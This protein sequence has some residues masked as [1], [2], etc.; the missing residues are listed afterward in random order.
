FLALSGTADPIAPPDV[1][2]AALDRMA[3]PRGHVLLTGQ[4]H[5]LDPASAADIVTWALGFLAAWVDGDAA[6]KSKL[7]QVEHVDGGLDDHKV[8]YVDPTG[9][10]VPGQ[11]VDTIEYYNAS[12]DHYFIT[13]F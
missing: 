3:G 5:D 10:G 4:G 2:R 13:A 12:L 1:V 9:G 6:S 8:F 11:V 7:T